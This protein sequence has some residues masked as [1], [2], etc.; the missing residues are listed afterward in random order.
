MAPRRAASPPR[1]PPYRVGREGR[2][3][4]GEPFAGIHYMN[5]RTGRQIMT[6]DTYEEHLADYLP[7][8]G[9]FAS[10]RVKGWRWG[11]PLPRSKYQA[12]GNIEALTSLNCPGA[13]WSWPEAGRHHHATQLH[14]G[15][16]NRPHAAMLP[17]NV[18]NLLVSVALS[19]PHIAMSV[20]RME[21]VWMTTGEIAGLASAPHGF[22][23]FTGTVTESVS[24]PP[25]TT[26]TRMRKRTGSTKHAEDCSVQ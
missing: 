3:E 10:G 21:P 22:G 13:S 11:A 26:T 5:W 12:N 16:Q 24:I 9:H 17:K 7:L 4:Y 19:S 8:R 20:V 2:G 6:P 14:G 18:D 15:P 1:K 23:T 25:S